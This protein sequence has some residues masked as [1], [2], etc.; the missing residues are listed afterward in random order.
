MNAENCRCQNPPI[1]HLDYIH[2]FIGIDET[3]GRFGEVAI[4]KCTH[5][6]SFW[7]SYFMEYESF[8]NSGRWYRG[9]IQSKDVA[10]INPEN[11][12]AYLQS[13]EWYIFG[14]SYFSSTGKIG[15]GKVIVDRP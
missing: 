1:S 13:M 2:C 4:Q 8:S 11:S 15:Q 9:M 14:G 3:N 5:C 7:L 12:I 6:N 10:H